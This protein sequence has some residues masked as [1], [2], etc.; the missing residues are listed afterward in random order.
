MFDMQIALT[1]TSHW[2]IA[3]RETFKTLI[4]RYL[5]QICWHIRRIFIVYARYPKILKFFSESHH[6]NRP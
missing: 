3:F 5:I 1:M 4:Y 6:A 2:M